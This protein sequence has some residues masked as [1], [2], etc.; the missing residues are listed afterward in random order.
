[1]AKMRRRD[2]I[3]LLGGAAASPLTAHAQHSAV[4]VIGYL[5]AGSP[6]ES[7]NLVEA[8]RKGLTETGY[9][10]GQNVA[11]EYRWA[12]NAF[13]RLPDLAAD[14]VRRRVAL[15]VTPGS[16]AAAL[17]A[18]GATATIPIVFGIGTDP[19]EAGLVASLNRPGGNVSG[20]SYMQAELAAKQLGLLHELL[21]EAT[22]F[23]VLVNP[24]N[25]LVTK[26]I[27]TDLESAASTIGGQIEV[28]PANDNR[29]I[30]AAFETIAQRRPDALL[31]SPGPLFGNRRVQLA[32]LAARHLVPAMYYDRQFPE[33][34]GLMSYGTS[35]A[36]QYRQT[37]IYSGRVL[38]GENPSDLPV[39][40]ATKF[41]LVINLQTA[42][43]FALAVPPSLLARADEVME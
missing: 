17:A 39:L 13:E 20:V 41:E 21:P 12:R 35:L 19:V 38:K 42:K 26:S 31:V 30:D 7:A 32:T 34:G 28:L 23:A 37:G 4:P 33:V 15:I 27:V 43:A 16:V 11:I 9:V 1:M 18:K 25:P 5:Y 14:L 22:R 2:F 24:N 36:D 40:R 3:T 29:D 8:F 6:E 10:E